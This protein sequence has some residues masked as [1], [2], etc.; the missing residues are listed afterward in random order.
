M[1]ATI[2]PQYLPWVGAIP[3]GITICLSISHVFNLII[4][5]RPKWLQP[6]VKEFIH[7]E[8]HKALLR[9]HG[10]LS[11]F[12]LFVLSICGVF[13]QAVIVWNSSFQLESLFPA[14]TWVCDI[15]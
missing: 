12:L 7:N 6:F 13:L 11:F 4:P 9:R 14:L 5:Y 2:C 10:R 3:L 15:I 8:P 1:N